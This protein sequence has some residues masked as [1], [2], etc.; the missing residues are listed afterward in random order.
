VLLLAHHE[1]HLLLLRL[2]PHAHFVKAWHR[3][4]PRPLPGKV[5]A[6]TKG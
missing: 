1:Q 2:L 4:T 5:V 6:I 3:N